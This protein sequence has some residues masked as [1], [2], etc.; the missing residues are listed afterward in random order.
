M[1][2]CIV[3]LFEIINEQITFADMYNAT[4]CSKKEWCKQCRYAKFK[5]TLTKWPVQKQTHRIA[6]IH[7]EHHGATDIQT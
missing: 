1:D 4:K 3:I 2:S 6:Q 5:G 7:A